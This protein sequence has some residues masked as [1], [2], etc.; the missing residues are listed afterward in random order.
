MAH[1]YLECG[2]ELISS[3]ELEFINTCTQI[4]HA[5]TLQRHQLEMQCVDHN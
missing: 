3:N 1:L 2:Q 5:V 4:C